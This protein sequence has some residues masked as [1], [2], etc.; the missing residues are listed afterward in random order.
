MLDGER[1]CERTLLEDIDARAMDPSYVLPLLS[2]L[3]PPSSWDVDT[4]AGGSAN[5]LSVDAGRGAGDG[6]NAR[7]VAHVRGGSSGIRVALGGFFSS[8]EFGSA[9]GSAAAR[10]GSL[11]VTIGG[12]S[13]TSLNSGCCCISGAGAGPSGEKFD[14]SREARWTLFRVR[15]NTKPTSRRM[16]MTAAET[17]AT[18][19]ATGTD[20]QKGRV[21]TI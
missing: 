2:L 12:S 17:G 8:V 14:A 9:N 19:A 11:M 13:V 20:L 16:K 7:W 1:G 10:A 3:S 18:T 21:S 6:A 15:R 4:S 5:G